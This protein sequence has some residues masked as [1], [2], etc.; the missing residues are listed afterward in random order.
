MTLLDALAFAWQMGDLDPQ[1][2]ELPTVIDG[3]FLQL[4]Q[5]EAQAVIDDF[6]S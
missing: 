2:T 1:P 6:S 4:K 3:P 5:P